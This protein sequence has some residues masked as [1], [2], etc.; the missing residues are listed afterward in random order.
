LKNCDMIFDI[1][2][3]EVVKSGKYTEIINYWFLFKFWLFENEFWKFYN[4]WKMHNFRGI[5]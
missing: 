3:G 2:N 4:R 5:K 1:K